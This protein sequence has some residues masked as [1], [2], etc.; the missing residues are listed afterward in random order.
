M[1]GNIKRL[2]EME[3]RKFWLYN[4]NPITGFKENTTVNPTK[5]DI[6]AKRH[7]VRHVGY[8]NFQI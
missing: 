1:A 7:L 8:K 6:T 4:I 2:E 3:T 5:I